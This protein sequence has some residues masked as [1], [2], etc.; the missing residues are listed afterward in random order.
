M[1]MFESPFQGKVWWNLF[2]KW[3]FYFW[4]E[5]FWDLPPELEQHPRQSWGEDFWSILPYLPPLW[6]DCWYLLSRFE[7]GFCC[8]HLYL[9]FWQFEPLV[10]RVLRGA[11]LSIYWCLLCRASGKGSFRLLSVFDFSA[12]KASIIVFLVLVTSTMWFLNFYPRRFPSFFWSKSFFSLKASLA[13]FEEPIKLFG[14]LYRL[15]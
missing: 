4:D 11:S 1:K 7:L 14:R 6:I 2:V 15:W 8:C 5:L 3:S 12:E 13:W 9:L 10:R